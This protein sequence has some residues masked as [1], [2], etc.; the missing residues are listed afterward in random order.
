MA[1]VRSAHMHCCCQGVLLL[2]WN[3]EAGGV[4]AKVMVVLAGAQASNNLQLRTFT[5]TEFT[6]PR[7]CFR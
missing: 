1:L 6:S 7:A 4:S 3:L 5:N 2:P